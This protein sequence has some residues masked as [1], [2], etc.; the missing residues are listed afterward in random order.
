[1]IIINKPMPEKL[2]GKTIIKLS[3]DYKNIIVLAPAFLP[4]EKEKAI[5]QLQNDVEQFIK[6]ELEKA[7]KQQEKY[8][9]IINTLTE[10][11]GG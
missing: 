8:N 4:S 5:K 7:K 11:M 1:M 6:I 10:A 9:T 2:P 3:E